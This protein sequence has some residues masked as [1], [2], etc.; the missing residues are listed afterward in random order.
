M[1]L[2]KVTYVYNIP[3]EI[4]E[5]MVYTRLSFKKSKTELVPE[6]VNEIRSACTAALQL[7]RPCGAY[8][9]V[10]LAEDEKSFIIDDLKIDNNLLKEKL[11]GSM[12]CVIAAVTL[13]K[14]IDEEITE[15]FFEDE[16][17]KAVVL[18][19]ISS[20]MVDAA[21]ESLKQY[22]NKL[23]VNEN[24]ELSKFR[25]SPGQL[26][27]P[28]SLQKAFYKKLG[29]E[30]LGLEIGEGMMLTPQKSV[31]SISGVKHGK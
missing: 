22:I 18:D 21:V 9:F 5:S 7:A 23:L 27:I 20:C 4:D 29:L 31:I 3:A 19:F 24:L 8:M 28:M 30:Y 12:A 11:S 14:N 13:G 17:T 25:I 2:N 6:I 15:L 1:D 10:P 26:D 16:Y